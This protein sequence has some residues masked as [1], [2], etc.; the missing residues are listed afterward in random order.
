MEQTKTTAIGTIILV[1][2]I[3]LTSSVIAFSVSAPYLENKQLKLYP[4]AEANLKFDLQN[5]GA[6]TDTITKV[7][8]VEGAEITELADGKDTYTISP[9]GL[10]TVNIKI[11]IPN[12]MDL[13]QTRHIKLSFTAKDE[14]AGGFSIG[15]S[16]GQ[17]FDV[18][19][20]EIPPTPAPAEEAEKAEISQKEISNTKLINYL[21][22]GLII[23]I[24]I[25]YVILRIKK[26]KRK[27]RKS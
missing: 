25:Y 7:E 10:T 26:T 18:V 12:D 24:I 3:L 17:E 15:S 27:T 6:T 16:I 5:S 1:V 23:L 13:G 14:E 9:G 22:A 8:I 11:T 19:I 4:G 2:L 21:I 20:G